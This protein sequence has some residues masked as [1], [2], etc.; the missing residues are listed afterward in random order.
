MTVL[1]ERCQARVDTVSESA[2]ASP[3][4]R[5][6]ANE[7]KYRR[8]LCT[9]IKDLEA[10]YDGLRLI[11]D[12][13]KGRERVAAWEGWKETAE[14]LLDELYFAEFLGIDRTTP[15]V[16]RVEEARER[17]TRLESWMTYGQELERERDALSAY[18]ERMKRGEK[19][20][21]MPPSHERP[22]PHYRTDAEIMQ[23]REERILAFYYHKRFSPELS[24]ESQQR[25]AQE[26]LFQDDELIYSILRKTGRQKQYLWYHL[27]FSFRFFGW[28]TDQ[29]ATKVATLEK[30][31]DECLQRMRSACTSAETWRPYAEQLAQERK[32]IRSQLAELRAEKNILEKWIPHAL[33]LEEKIAQL[34]AVI[35]EKR[36]TDRVQR[37]AQHKM[38]EDA[39]FHERAQREGLVHTVQEMTA[40][41]QELDTAQSWEPYAHGLEKELERLRQQGEDQTQK[42]G[43]ERET[44]KS[45]VAQWQAY[46]QN[47][48]GPGQKKGRTPPR[49]PEEEQR[50]QERQER[51]VQAR[52][53]RDRDREER[54]ALQK[55]H[56]DEIQE[57]RRRREFREHEARIDQFN[58]EAAATPL[59]DR[60]RKEEKEQR[61][62][63]R[64]VERNRRETRKLLGRDFVNKHAPYL[65]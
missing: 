33:Q 62:L 20:K 14:D 57:R 27:C 29:L 56:M 43:A 55:E 50:E 35:K 26:P 4:Y 15:L 28:S 58:R 24:E 39:A 10:E 52:A 46:A 9:R 23:R 65:K 7:R 18:L 42:I 53:E 30:V 41:Q 63:E 16:I 47:N 38:E 13:G 45:I 3:D 59:Q 1:E 11:L 6:T 12:Q 54:R 49:T 32:E 48:G 34:Q 21:R 2:P 40:L 60:K 22:A 61:R 51:I 17:N 64:E 37:S 36:R 8:E 5:R 19:T 44:W 25:L 31:R